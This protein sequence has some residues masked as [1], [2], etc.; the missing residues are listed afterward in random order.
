VPEIGQFALNFLGVSLT[1]NGAVAL[2]LAVVPVTLV[3]GAIA[4]RITRTGSPGN[5]PAG[6]PVGHTGPPSVARE[7]RIGGTLES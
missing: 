2:W 4:Y 6:G 3:L 1:A 7:T 5:A